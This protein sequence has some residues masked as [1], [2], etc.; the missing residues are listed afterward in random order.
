[1]RAAQDAVTDDR[2][3]YRI[4][5]L[6]PGSYIVGVVSTS[7]TM[8]AGLATEIDVAAP[9]PN[10]AFDVES[11]L[12]PGGMLLLNGHLNGAERA[13]IDGSCNEPAPRRRRG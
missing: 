2:G 5:Q 12:L 3:I 4:A 11:S 9:N 7:M 8:P 10:A 13:S 6:A 1:V